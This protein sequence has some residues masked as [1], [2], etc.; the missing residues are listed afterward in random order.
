MSRYRAARTTS[1]GVISSGLDPRPRGAVAPLT[2]RAGK[3][4]AVVI[5]TYVTDDDESRRKQ[6]VECDVILVKSQV[7]LP[8][9]PVQQRNH[10]VND[11]WAPWVPRESTRLVTTGDAVSFDGRSAPAAQFGDLD[12]DHVYVEFIEGD[13]DHP[14]ITGAATHEQTKRLIVGVRG[15]DDAGRGWR[16]GG[17][18][19]DY[20]GKPS[21]DEYFVSHRGVEQRVG[22]KG[23]VLFD[24]VG[25]HDDIVNESPNSDG[26]AFR[27]RM[28][29]SK[30][31]TI[32]M[33]G[34]DVLEV[35]KD[36]SQVRIDFGEG[37][38]QRIILGDDF[39]SFLNN[40]M[41]TKFDLHVHTAGTLLDSTA[42]ACTGATGVATGF[43][44]TQMSDD[45]LSDLAKV[46]K[47]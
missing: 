34:V 45:L 15:D 25:A 19:A 12:G 23:D 39:K 13:P 21:R 40:W 36:G 20:R 42:T 43:T 37:A 17:D 32:E 6:G 11:V 8:R 28:K 14:V 7:P 33:D 16:E 24:T 2:P 46:K 18:A 1:G 31:F 4:R 35:W 41:S 47:S 9:V 22:G 29:S 44:G 38:A 30:R 5:N 26:G 3:Y 10:G 27:I